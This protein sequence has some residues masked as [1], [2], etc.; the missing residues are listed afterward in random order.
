LC[1]SHYDDNNNDNSDI[2]FTK[3]NNNSVQLVD[4]EAKTKTQ[5]DMTSHNAHDV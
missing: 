1:H 5:Q 3:R 2:Y 4:V